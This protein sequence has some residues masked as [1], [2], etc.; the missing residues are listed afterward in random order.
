MSRR[1]SLFNHLICYREDLQWLDKDN[2]G[3][4]EKQTKCLLELKK[5]FD[6]GVIVQI[7]IVSFQIQEDVSKIR[8]SLLIGVFDFSQETDPVQTSTS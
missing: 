2:T 4:I 6:S 1:K 8:K 3:T 7:V 5:S